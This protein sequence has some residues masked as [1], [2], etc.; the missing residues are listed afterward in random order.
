MGNLGNPAPHR[1][2]FYTK[3]TSLPVA[4]AL[5]QRLRW[6]WRRRSKMGSYDFQRHNVSRLQRELRVTGCHGPS[7]G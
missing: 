3:K 4:Q 1:L 6:R 7:A 2:I 5:L